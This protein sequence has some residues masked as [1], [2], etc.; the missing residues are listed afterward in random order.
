M[1]WIIDCFERQFY[2]FEVHHKNTSWFRSQ[3]LTLVNGFI[4]N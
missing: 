4:Y 1:V 3:R 2:F